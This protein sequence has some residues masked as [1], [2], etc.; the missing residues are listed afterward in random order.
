[1]VKR[2]HCYVV[3]FL[4]FIMVTEP[5][6]EDDDSDDALFTI[7]RMMAAR[8]PYEQVVAA[9]DAL[10]IP[11]DEQ[12]MASVAHTRLSA[13]SMYERPDDEI[14]QAIHS[15]LAVEPVPWRRLSA[16]LAACG[17]SPERFQRHVEPLV[18]MSM[19]LDRDGPLDNVLEAAQQVRRRLLDPASQE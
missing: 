16:V 1:M 3:G 15:Y 12:A 4:V 13:A 11:D 14:A 8:A 19:T 17:E 5:G 6:E 9:L 2:R 7:E 10:E 18:T